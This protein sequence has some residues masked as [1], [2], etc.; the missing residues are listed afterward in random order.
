MSPA[1]W[2][3]SV[4]PAAIRDAGGRGRFDPASSEHLDEKGQQALAVGL[5]RA[6]GA[7]RARTS[8]S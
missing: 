8:I 5:R 3:L 4:T 7:R 1:C 6:K 2:H